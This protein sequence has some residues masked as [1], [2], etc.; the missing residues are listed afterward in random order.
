[1]SG[2]ENLIRGN[3]RNKEEVRK[4]GSKDGK[5]SVKARREKKGKA[6]WLFY[7]RR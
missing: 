5:A 6:R 2:K 7:G 3:R 1:M 4:I